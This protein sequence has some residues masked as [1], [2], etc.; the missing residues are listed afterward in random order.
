MAAFTLAFFIAGSLYFLSLPQITKKCLG[1]VGV[2]MFGLCF[3]QVISSLFKQGPAIVIDEKGIDDLQWGWGVIP[4]SDII[5]V[6]V[7]TVKNTRFLSIETKNPQAYLS[8]VKG[9]TRIWKFTNEIFGFP[10]ICS[11]FNILTPGVDE[12]FDHIKAK[13]PKKVQ[14]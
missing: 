10:Q 1:G 11:N 9:I 7:R 13:Y 8:K 14:S 12:A 6:S 2:F 5:C 4:W 3:Y